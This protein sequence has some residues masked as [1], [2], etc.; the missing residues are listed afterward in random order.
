[1]IIDHDYIAEVRLLRPAMILPSPQTVSRD[2]AGIY[3]AGTHNAR[4]Y[5]ADR[6]SVTHLSLDGRSA[7]IVASYL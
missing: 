1:M 5:F 4:Q 2:T 6:D 3:E 7:S